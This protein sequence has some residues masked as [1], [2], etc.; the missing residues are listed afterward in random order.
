MKNDKSSYIGLFIIGLL[1]FG[2]MYW[3]AP[4]EKDVAKQK[5]KN[6][7]VARVQ[8]QRDEQAATAAQAA[9][10]TPKNDSARVAD[11]ASNISKARTEAGIFYA[12]LSGTNQDI[13][14]ENDLLKATVST[15]GGKISTVQLKNF[16][17]SAGGPLVLFFPKDNHFSLVL[18]A[19]S[20]FFSTDSLYFSQ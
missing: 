11:S 3:Q 19:Y 12:A 4:S 17:T 5:A 13:T 20:K 16:K 15:K 2:W 9:K 8:K 14:L 10:A 6:D 18:N 7:S 1:L